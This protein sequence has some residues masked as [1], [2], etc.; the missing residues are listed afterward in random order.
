[1][2][3]QVGSFCHLGFG[4]AAKIIEWIFGESLESAGEGLDCRLAELAQRV[5]TALAIGREA[6]GRTRDP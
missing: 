6:S 4:G 3:K 2:G 1:V 5:V